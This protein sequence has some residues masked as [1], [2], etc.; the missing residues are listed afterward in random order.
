MKYTKHFFWRHDR[1]A[2][3]C[4]F[5]ITTKYFLCHLFF[6][7]KPVPL[8]RFFFDV[9]YYYR[10]ALLRERTFSLGFLAVLVGFYR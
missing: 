7:L 3:S 10:G 9:V 6:N 8:W 4:S 5:A 1:L 2:R